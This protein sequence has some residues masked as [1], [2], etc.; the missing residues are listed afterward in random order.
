MNQKKKLL[1]DKIKEK[2]GFDENT[3]LKKSDYNSF[4]KLIKKYTDNKLVTPDYRCT[5]D[6]IINWLLDHFGSFISI[7][8]DL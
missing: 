8:P 4:I 6:E 1:D 5:K 3:N 7:I 2:F